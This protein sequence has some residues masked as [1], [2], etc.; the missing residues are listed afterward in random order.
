MKV[1]QAPAPVL[2]QKAKPIEKVDKVIKK[3]LVDMEHTLNSQVDPEG[4]GLA[5][6][7]V[8]KSLRLFIAKHA[9]DAPMMTFINPIIEK[10]FEKPVEKHNG[11]TAKKKKKED[12]GVQ[13]EGCLSLKDVWGV[14]RRPHGVVVTYLDEKGNE[15]HKTFE[16]FLATI[17]QHE[18][19]HLDGILFP[20]RVLEQKNPLYHS[21][22]NK[23][24]EIEFDEIEI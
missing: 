4:V 18:V 9:P 15:H 16:G 19:D 7:Q 13:L 1:V 21:T 12:K 14:V 5:A 24:G 20:K 3:L 17:I 23:K 11:K 2:A 10:T 6:P 8:G 22:K